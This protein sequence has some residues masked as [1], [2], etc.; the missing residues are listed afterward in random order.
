MQIC[1]NGPK[2]DQSEFK[3]ENSELLGFQVHVADLNGVATCIG[4]K[5][6]VFYSVS[7]KSHNF[8]FQ[9][10][11]GC[12]SLRWWTLKKKEKKNQSWTG[13]IQFQFSLLRKPILV[14]ACVV[15]NMYFPGCISQTAKWWYATCLCSRPTKSPGGLGVLSYGVLATRVHMFTCHMVSHLCV[16]L[17]WWP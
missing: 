1:S 12:S 6:H 7:V 14:F 3:E 5:Q 8:I 17:C 16:D 15:N 10:S 13:H 2:Y 9:A 4:K 11:V